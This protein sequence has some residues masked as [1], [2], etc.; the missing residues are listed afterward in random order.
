MDHP[1][2]LEEIRDEIEEVRKQYPSWTREA[3]QKLWKMD[4]FMKESSRINPLGIAGIIRSVTAPVTFKDG[5]HLPKGAHMVVPLKAV[6]LDP[7]NYRDPLVFD[8][9]RYLRMRQTVDPNRFH[10]AAISEDCLGFGIGMRACSGRALGTDEIK[11]MLITLCTK[12]EWKHVRED[13]KRPPPMPSDVLGTFP[14]VTI[15][16]LIRERQA[17]V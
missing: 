6:Q 9:H 16:I 3:L 11:L 8:P 7:R 13:Q 5:L 1:D 10:F 2:S 4:S 14:N 15:P 12:Y 17:L